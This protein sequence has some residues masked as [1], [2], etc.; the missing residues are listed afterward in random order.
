MTP[1]EQGAEP[2]QSS[3]LERG[4]LN[5]RSRVFGSIVSSWPPIVARLRR[6][7][8]WLV[9]GIL[10]TGLLAGYAGYRSFQTEQLAAPVRRAFAEARFEEAR[11]PLRHWIEARPTSGE[12]QY[13][14]AWLG[15]VDDRP[16]ETAT[17][18]RR[19]A[20]LG[21]DRRPLEI[22]RAIYQARAHQTQAAE[23]ILLKAFEEQSEPR[24]EVARELARIYLETYRLTQAAPAIER[25]RELRP[26]DPQPYLWR[27]EIAS[28]MS[29]PP[30]VLIRNYRAA[31]ERSPH[32]EKARIGLAEQLVKDQRFDEAAREYRRYLADH[33]KDAGAKVGLGRCALRQGNIEAAVR[34]FEDALA[35]APQHPEALQEIAQLDIRF[36]RLDR[37]CQRL[38][39]LT[40]AEP[41]RHEYHYAH[42][43]ALKLAGRDAE[44]R[45]ESQRAAQLRDEEDRMLRVRSKILLDPKDVASR[46]EVA[47]WMLGHGQDREGLKWAHEILGTDPHHVPTHEL[48]AGYYEKQG[49]A[50]L[51]NYHRMMADRGRIPD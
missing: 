43:Q 38:E 33:P 9:F 3:A 1:R 16:N 19:A 47:R 31:L 30:A 12:A 23:P 14:R 50:G 32:L 40:R 11:E 41:F 15:L 25:Y 10:A 44:A 35:V 49:N 37:A 4:I 45:R 8:R 20:D 21:Y 36:G 51:A 18:F 26:S 6:I 22:I 7:P 29:D 34:A 46:L 28:R 24:A 48:L 27:I 5:R 39:T 17:A 42:A 13:Y 2:G